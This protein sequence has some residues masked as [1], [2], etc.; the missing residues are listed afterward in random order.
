MKKNIFGMAVLAALTLTSCKQEKATP[1]ASSE[2][3]S[4]ESVNNDSIIAAAPAN[5]IV[6]STL[7]DNSG[8][9]LEV[10]FDNTKDIAT[11][12]FNG[13]SLELKG[14]RPASGIWYKNDHYELRGKGDDVQLSKDGKVVF[15]SAAS[16]ATAD[17]ILK[18]TLK[19]NSGKTLEVTFDNT[20]DIATLIFNGE[21]LE[22]KGQRPASGIWY[23]NDHYELRGKGDD[24][25]LSKDGKVV[26]ANIK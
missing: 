21:S 24:V 23:K 20:K 2:T 19:D 10:T 25:Q 5:D 11:L 12:V 18:S 6:K 1:E 26:F 17:D 15:Q 22:L 7:K 13:E 16:T 9:T 8:K 4:A 3:Q 14:Q